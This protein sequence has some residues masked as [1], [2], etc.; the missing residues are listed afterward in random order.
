MQSPPRAGWSWSDQ[1]E[2]HSCSYSSSSVTVSATVSEHHGNHHRQREPRDIEELKTTSQ[3][4]ITTED[5]RVLLD[6]DLW[7]RNLAVIGLLL[8]WG[9][10]IAALATGIFIIVSPNVSVPEYLLG[11]MVMVGP[12]PFLWMEVDDYLGGHRI[13]KVTESAM[14]AL[15]LLMQV[16][17]TLVAGCLGSIHATTLRWALLHEGRNP[18]NSSL[19]LFT[20]SKSNGPNKWQA[21]TVACIGLVLAYGGASTMSFPVSVIGVADFTREGDPYV[22]GVEGIEDRS[23]I[24]FN[25]W[26]L[27]G[28]GAGFFLQAIISTW[29]LMDSAYVGTWNA[30]PLATARA[31]RRL[32]DTTRDPLASDFDWRLAPISGSSRHDTR[33]SPSPRLADRRPN[34]SG[35]VFRQP[36]ARHLFPAVRILTNCIWAVSLVLSI[37][38]LVIGILASQDGTNNTITG[39]STSIRFVKGLTGQTS[40]WYVWQFFGI[41]EA[42]YNRNPYARGEWAGLLIQCAALTIPIFGLHIVELLGQLQRDESIWR[43]ASTVGAKIDSSTIL[44]G[45]RNWP[46]LVIFATKAVVPWVFSFAIS[47]NRIIYFVTLPTLTLAVIFLI[48]GLFS[49]YLIRIRPKGSQPATYGD[50]QALLAL[51][52]D[53]DHTRIFWGD[54]GKY[55]RGV[56]LAGTA[57]R[58][59]ADVRADVVYVGLSRELGSRASSG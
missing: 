10:S 27:V 54:K 42:V 31:C 7:T 59:L 11:K 12:T 6:R 40:P 36:S 50:I 2:A 46:T 35:P 3:A 21:N 25:G 32:Y 28:L 20:S 23:G 24:D 57:G 39:G 58:R 51:V 9:G 1:P 34:L 17:I 33:H 8:T 29:A 55:S 5:S 15:P 19:R 14:V 53:W 18:H 47:C 45:A 41:V 26:G 38:V 22:F 48:L 49:E 56:R 4:H 52:D 43:R 13:Y 37:M 44:E 30:S 16:V